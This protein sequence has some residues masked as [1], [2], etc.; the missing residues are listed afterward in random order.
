MFIYAWLAH[1][2]THPQT[3][4]N[5]RHVDGQVFSIYHITFDAV[6]TLNGMQGRRGRAKKFAAASKNLRVVGPCSLGAVQP[7]APRGRQ[8]K[9]RFVEKLSLL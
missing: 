5:D 1:T 9:G 3:K 7:A 4:F 2:H 8:K 6:G